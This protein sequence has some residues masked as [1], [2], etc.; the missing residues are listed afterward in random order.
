MNIKRE[1]A[2]SVAKALR[3]RATD[4]RSIGE[5]TLALR[6]DAMAGDLEIKYDGG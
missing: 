3:A 6:L 1:V 4:L 2:L 5:G